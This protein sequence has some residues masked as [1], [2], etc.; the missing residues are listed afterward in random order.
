MGVG[1]ERYACVHGHFYQPPREDPR[2]G[3]IPVEPSAAPFPNWNARILDECYRPGVANYA[4]MSFN[5]GP[6]L[7]GW[8]AKAAPEV[9]AAIVQAD[10]ESARRFGGHGSAIAQ[11]H[12]HMILPL[13]NPR[14]KV[15]QVRWGIRDFEHH[16]GRR[17]EGMWLPETAVDTATLAV[18]AEEG[19]RFTILAPS[20]AAGGE[21]DTGRAHWAKLPGGAELALFFYDGATAQAVAF[22]GLLNDGD[23][24]ARRLLEV[25]SGEGPRLA[26]IATDGESY[27]HH[28]RFGEMALTRALERIDEAEGARLTNYG[29]FLEHNAPSGEVEIVERSS[30]SCVHGVERWRSDCGCSAGRGE[31]WSQEW[32]GPLREALDG[33]RESLAIAFERG[34]EGVLPDPWAARN[35]YID[36]VLDGSPDQQ[37]AFLA[38]HAAP[39]ASQ[40]ESARALTLLDSQRQAMLMYTSCG[41]FFDDI[42]GI[43]PRQILRHAAHA[44]RLSTQATGTSPEPVFL[45]ALTRAKSN[46]TALPHGKAVYLAGAAGD[47][48]A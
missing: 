4:R 24:F 5:F 11:A 17:P 20:Q 42:A 46:T 33:L 6:T 23:E 47:A 32:R 31:G 2:T 1:V 26:H 40:E 21:V 7:L 36:V 13:A 16:F 10:Q 3:E 8:M 27:G 41:W 34:T 37:A 45:E 15:T 30:W 9:H 44:I 28:H 25:G 14:D 18:M 48:P 29:E 12:N 38:A 39:A 35:A 43:E 22:G 19:I